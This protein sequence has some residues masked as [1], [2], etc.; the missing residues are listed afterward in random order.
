MSA[1]RRLGALALKE[2]IE[3]ALVLTFVFAL[4]SLGWLLFLLAAFGSPTTVTYL[5]AHGNFTR[6]ALP[7]AAMALGNRLVV[8]ELSGRTQRFLESLPM[9]PGEPLLVKW[10]FG[11]SVLEGFGLTSL[12]RRRWSRACASPWTRSFSSS[13]PSGPWSASARCGRSSSRWGSSA[14]SAC[15]SISCSVSAWR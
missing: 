14:S 2:I 15:L 7:M 10:L 4:L 11:L 8:S 13:S 12:V 1:L 5:E 3:H 6:F 9:R